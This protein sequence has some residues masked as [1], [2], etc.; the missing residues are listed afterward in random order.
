MPKNRT[1]QGAPGELSP[2]ARQ[3]EGQALDLVDSLT[4][5]DVPAPRG[6]RTR[7][8][9]LK[10]LLGILMVLVAGGFVSWMAL[11]QAALDD[12]QGAADLTPDR[13][14]AQAP[15]NPAPAAPPAP[16]TDAAQPAPTAAAVPSRAPAGADTWRFTG[17]WGLDVTITLLPEGDGYGRIRVRGEPDAKGSYTWND[18]TLK[19]AYKQ[20]ATL[21]TGN[22]VDTKGRFTCKGQPT[23]AKVRCTIRA[24]GWTSTSTSQ[25]SQWLRFTATGRPLE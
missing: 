23:S 13:P 11:R 22:V 15:A 18:S 1:P 20:P 14:V 8:F 17:R 2:G 12:P 7:T 3:I 16:A 19:I 5:F 10:V 24:L 21:L 6:R 25:N 9:R 4:P